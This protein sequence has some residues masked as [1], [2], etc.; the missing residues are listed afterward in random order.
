MQIGE[1][2]AHEFKGETEGMGVRKKGCGKRGEGK[3]QREGKNRR[4]R[5]WIDM[6]ID[7]LHKVY[8]N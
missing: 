1:K 5:G 2:R 7:T 8:V 3:T 6:R 4:G